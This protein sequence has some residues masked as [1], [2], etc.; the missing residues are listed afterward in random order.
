[1]NFRK[2]KRLAGLAAGLAIVL[3][4]CGGTGNGAAADGASSSKPGQEVTNKQENSTGTGEKNKNTETEL[5][6]ESEK[7]S[8]TSAVIIDPAGKNVETR[9]RTPEDFRRTKADKDSLSVF[10]RKYPLKKDG[11]PVLLYNGKKKGNQSVHAAVFK[12]PIEAENLQQCADSIMRVYGEYYYHMGAYEKIQFPMGDGFVADFG[13][14]S[15]GY[16]IGVDGDHLFWTKND[17]NDN[18]YAS[19]QK[20]MRIVFAYS[21][22]LNM[23]ENSKK[24]PLSDIA[25][26]DIFIKGGSPGHVVMVVDIC[27]NTKGEKAFLLGQGY[28]P[29][30]E[31]HV[32]KNPL[33]PEDPWYYQSEISYPLDTGEYTF[34][35]KSLKRINLR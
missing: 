15:Q 30:Q 17:K 13:K 33:H 2:S 14:W 32:L 6:K 22:T 18:S 25:V 5:K 27:E 24:I 4:A 29:A 9:F 19:F 26:G 10:L 23:N 34:S 28:M 11:S 12:L 3:T 7:A 20:F 8:E 1:M 31:F 16:G 21:G 35:K